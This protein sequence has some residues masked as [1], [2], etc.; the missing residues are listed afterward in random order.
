M[1][2]IKCIVV[3]D[4]PIARQYLSDYVAKMPQLELLAV[5]SSAKDAWE[6]IETGAAELVFLD[7]QM[8]GLTG[9]EFIRTLQKK[10]AIILTTAY[11]EYALEGYELDVADYLLKPISFDRFAKA[12]NKVADRPKIQAGSISSGLPPSGENHTTTRNFIFVKSGYK[13][14]K[15]NISDILYVEGMKE[16]VVIHTKDKKFTKLDRMKNVENLLKEQGFI[17]IHKSYI[18]SIKNIESVFG[19]TLEI[20]GKQLPLGRNFRDEVNNALG[21]NE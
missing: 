2:R 9:I 15:V 17:R 1:E 12:V 3:D 14:V 8:P 16:Y 7:I 11:S 18:A 13:S 5:F 20:N 6:I 4:E 19:N 21:M 10:P